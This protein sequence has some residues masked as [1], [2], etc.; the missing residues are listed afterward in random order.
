MAKIR[1][2]IL[3]AAN[4]APRFVRAVQNTTDGEVT[5]IASRDIGK[6]RRMAEE[7]GVLKSYGSYEELV[8]D[9]GIDAVYIATPN[10]LHKEH[11]I[12]GL[13]HGKHVV[14]EKPFTLF[15]SDAH[16]VFSMAREKGLFVMEAQKSVF[17]PVTVDIKKIL[18]SGELGKIRLIDCCQ[19]ATGFIQDWFYKRES[20][21]GALNG[22]LSYPLEHAMFLTGSVIEKAAGTATIGE[23]GVDLQCAVSVSLKDGTLLTSRITTLVETNGMAIIWCEKGR[24]EIPDFWKARHARVF[25]DN[26]REIRIDHPCEHE[27]TY[28]VEHVNS[29]IREGLSESPVMTENM[30][31]MAV[32]TVENVR[33]M[34]WRD[35]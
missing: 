9:P 24:V 17:L 15:E 12:L 35:L 5:A 23:T 29:R 3:G 21:G 22:S 25:F 19:S 2:G 10:S 31:C 26:G 11:M 8:E 34:I 28:E 4:V 18:D 20:G 7:L 27:M 14:C 1:Y 33:N 30:T 13:E 16:E 32:R 6:A